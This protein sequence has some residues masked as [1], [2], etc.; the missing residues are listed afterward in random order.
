MIRIYKDNME[1]IEGTKKI[2]Y[3]YAQYNNMVR[4]NMDIL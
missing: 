3:I 2:S 4:W 1:W